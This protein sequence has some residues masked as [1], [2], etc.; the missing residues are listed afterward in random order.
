[1]KGLGNN[2]DKKWEGMNYRPVDPP[3]QQAVAAAI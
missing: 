3:S 2:E 1:M